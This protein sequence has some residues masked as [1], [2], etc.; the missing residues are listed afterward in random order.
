MKYNINK[1]NN[2][3]NK[4]K[5]GQEREKQAAVFLERNGYHII[6]FN[7]RNRIGEIDIIA[8]DK[9]SIVFVEVK[10][11]SSA[12]YGWPEEAVDYKKQKNIIAVVNYFI[13]SNN[14]VDVPM[15]FDVV[16]ILNNKIEHIQNAFGV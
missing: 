7:Y 5:V 14:L 11:R 15:R 8:R 1:R 2:K 3:Y 13:M 10:Y 6:T 4:R 16:S 12:R 9:E